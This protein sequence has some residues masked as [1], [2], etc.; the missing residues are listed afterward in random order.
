MHLS[1]AI[2]LAEIDN[3]EQVPRLSIRRESCLSGLNIIAICSQNTTF[4]KGLL[5]RTRAMGLHAAIVS[6]GAAMTIIESSLMQDYTAYPF[7][8]HQDSFRSETISG[9]V[10]PS[11]GIYI[12]DDCLPRST[13]RAIQFPVCRQEK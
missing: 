3:V 7:S 12:K 2:T 11:L 5:G 9:D 13:L 10:K 1:P 4:C 8:H 6:I